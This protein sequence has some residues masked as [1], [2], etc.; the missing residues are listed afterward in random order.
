[1]SH[2]TKSCLS[3]VTVVTVSLPANALSARSQMENCKL[4]LDHVQLKWSHIVG[5]QNKKGPHRAP[6]FA[7]Q[8]LVFVFRA[9]VIEEVPEQCTW[10]CLCPDRCP[11]GMIYMEHTVGKIPKHQNS[12]QSK[13]FFL[14][15]RNLRR[16]MKIQCTQFL[17]LYWHCRRQIS[18]SNNQKDIFSGET[19]KSV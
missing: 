13:I 4:G 9:S 2:V 15:L 8:I 1:M 7:N 16:N 3:S 6:L 10:G 5:M 11:E 12:N 14:I 18:W 19:I 17:A